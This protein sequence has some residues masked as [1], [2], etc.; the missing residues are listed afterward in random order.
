MSAADAY[1]A[2]LAAD[3]AWGDELRRLFGKRAGDV[4]YTRQGMGDPESELRRLHDAKVLTGD[5]WLSVMK[6]NRQ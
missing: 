1:K 3:D 5:V 2:A 4:R 6:G